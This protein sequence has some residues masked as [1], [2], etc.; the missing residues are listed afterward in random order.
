M[1]KSTWIYTALGVIVAAA[2]GVAY[3]YIMDTTIED[4][5][6]PSGATSLSSVAPPVQQ[7]D[8]V[9]GKT[10]EGIG[11]IKNLQPV[12]LHPAPQR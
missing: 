10:L 11:S 4:H 12:P 8:D 5:V 6:P 2:G 9:K 1:L 3:S 7:D